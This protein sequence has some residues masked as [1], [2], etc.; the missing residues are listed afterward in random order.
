[1]YDVAEVMACARKAEEV[2]LHDWAVFSGSDVEMAAALGYDTVEVGRP[3][4]G[5]YKVAAAAVVGPEAGTWTMDGRRPEAVFLWS[6][7]YDALSADLAAASGFE[8]PVP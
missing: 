1:M 3:A 7:G 6:G 4:M 8:V 2:V 5:S